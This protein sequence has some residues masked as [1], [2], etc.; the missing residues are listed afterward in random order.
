MK[1]AN[2]LLGIALVCL[3]ALSFSVCDN[4][5]SKPPAVGAE[6]GVTGSLSENSEQ[7]TVFTAGIEKLSQEMFGDVRIASEEP[8]YNLD[9]SPDFIYVEFTNSGYAVFAAESLELLE[10]SAQGSL[11]YQN[12]QSRRYYNGPKNYLTKVN[13][14]F[15]DEVTNESFT[16][17]VSEAKEYSQA[18]RQTF[19]ISEREL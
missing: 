17:S 4:P 11:P 3:S 7:L 19:S 16:I 18:I 10:Y 1:K 5:F 2:K 12:T 9:E 6:R 14:Q 15:V 8:L 13:D